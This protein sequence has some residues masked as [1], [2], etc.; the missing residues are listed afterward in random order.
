M[1]TPLLSV[2]T[3]TLR[4]PR[5]VADLL[6]NLSAQTLRPDELLL[7]DGAPA[8]ETA[9]EGV[10]R[11]SA[12]T[13]PF[14][15]RYIRHAGG[16]AIQRNAGID[17]ARGS[18]VAFVD[19]DVRLRPDF[20]ETMLDVLRSPGRQDVGGVVGYRDN[21]FFEA[22]ESLRWRWYRRLGLLKTFEPGRYDFASGYPINANLQPAFRGVR[23]V[24]FM[25]TSCA[26]WRREVFDEGLRFDPFFKDYGVLEDAHLSLRAGR[27]WKLLQCGDARCEE[28][29]VASSREDRR[30]IGYKCVVNYYYV[31]REAA[32]PLSR[33]QKARFL[34]FQAFE[35]LRILASAIRRR[36]WADVEELKGRVHGLLELLSKEPEGA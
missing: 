21:Q 14:D 36:R 9:T 32:G 22:G 27:R 25:S 33:V 15:C 34:R 11:A 13:L 29:H 24:D 4:R 5:E 23:P 28:L 18:F 26:V 19:D 17:A 6:V 31:F 2:V 16:T 30:R 1:T 8:G 10:A 12:A 20:F 35:L 7:V 3:P